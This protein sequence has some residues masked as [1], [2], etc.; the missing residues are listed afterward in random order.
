M[1]SSIDAAV[2]TSPKVDAVVECQL[3]TQPPPVEALREISA[4][5]V[6]NLACFADGTP[7]ANVII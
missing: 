7:C 2:P 5:T 6:S 4:V 3:G 1:P